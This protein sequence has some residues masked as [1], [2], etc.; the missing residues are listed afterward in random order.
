MTTE[1]ATALLEELAGT[2]SM[3]DIDK[4]L[5]THASV[6]KKIRAILLLREDRLSRMQQLQI[7]MTL[8]RYQMNAMDDIVEKT[9]RES[10]LAAQEISVK[11]EIR[12]IEA[13]I[14]RIDR[15]LD[16]L[17]SSAFNDIKSSYDSAE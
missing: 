9:M 15:W 4:L 6:S 12:D 14:Q 13:D 11:R 8:T 2:L 5:S 17:D 3:P 7:N 10:L 16:L 1:R